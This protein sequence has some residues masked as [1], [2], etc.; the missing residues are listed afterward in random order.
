MWGCARYIPN[1]FPHHYLGENCVQT[2]KEFTH[3]FSK[4][5]SDPQSNND[6]TAPVYMQPLIDNRMSRT[7][8]YLIL[9]KADRAFCVHEGISFD[10]WLSREIHIYKHLDPQS[11]SSARTRLGFKPFQ[12]CRSI[13]HIE[14]AECIPSIPALSFGR[15]R[16]TCS[17][18]RSS[19]NSA[20]SFACSKSYRF[21]SE[22]TSKPLFYI[23]IGYPAT[24][25]F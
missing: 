18:L 11:C 9:V 15:S 1:N 10:L 5:V 7:H 25:C 17:L 16:K 13:L 24:F 14:G 12:S 8:K 4:A 3:L 19:L 23:T 2:S 21:L 6:L 20:T 22:Q